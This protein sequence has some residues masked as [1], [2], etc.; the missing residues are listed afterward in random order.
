MLIF[1]EKI[2][3]KIFRST[4]PSPEGGWC[5]PMTHDF[6]RDDEQVNAAW[7]EVYPLL[8]PHLNDQASEA[9]GVFTAATS[10]HYVEGV[11][12]DKYQVDETYDPEAFFEA[13][14]PVPD[15]S[16]EQ[17]KA[18]LATFRALPREDL[19]A[20]IRAAWPKAE[21]AASAP[22]AAEQFSSVEEYLAYL[23]DWQAVLEELERDSCGLA[24]GIA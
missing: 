14:V 12:F 5:I 3:W 9:L 15:L 17:V 2:D 20:Q 19:V 16:P 18:V 21:I 24:F 11:E 8:Q 22:D 1:P 23:D 6:Q 13:G 7:A 4:F 10:G